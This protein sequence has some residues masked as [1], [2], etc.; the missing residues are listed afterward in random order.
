MPPPPEENKQAS[1]QAAVDI[2]WDISQILNCHLDRREISICTSLIERGINPEALAVSFAFAS[3]NLWFI[4][5]FLGSSPSHTSQ[6]TIKELRK[7]AQEAKIEL[8]ARK[9]QK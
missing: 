4:S 1:A 2:L 9:Q 5:P 8:E 3:M 6:T 7:G